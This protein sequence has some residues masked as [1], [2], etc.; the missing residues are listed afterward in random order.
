[1]VVYNASVYYSNK[2]LDSKLHQQRSFHSTQVSIV[3]F[4]V[5]YCG[6]ILVIFQ[7]LWTIDVH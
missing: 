7:V 5:N 6:A 1:M 4:V 2:L 3:Q